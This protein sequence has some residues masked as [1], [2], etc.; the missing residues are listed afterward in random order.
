M[1][2]VEEIKKLVKDKRLVLGAARTL[3]NLQTGRCAKVWFSSNVGDD[4]K[5]DVLRYAK[6]NGVPVEQLP[7]PND[8]LGLLCKKQFAVS[9]PS[10]SNRAMAGCSTKLFS[11]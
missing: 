11:V 6:L 10:S 8:E 3:R 5:Q 2:A 7:I 4:A 1:D 9:Q